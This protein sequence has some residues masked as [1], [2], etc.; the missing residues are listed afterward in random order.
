MSTDKM[1]KIAKYL[2]NVGLIT[3]REVSILKYMSRL[4]F[5]L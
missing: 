4:E 5:T 1:I 2:Q 3:Y